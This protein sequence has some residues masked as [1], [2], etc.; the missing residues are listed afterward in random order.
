MFIIKRYEELDSIRGLAS[1]TVVICHIISVSSA[2]GLVVFLSTTPFLHLFF[3]SHEAVIMFFVLSGFVLSLPALSGKKQTYSEFIIRRIARIYIPYVITILI[4]VLLKEKFSNGGIDGLTEWFNRLWV[5][6]FNWELFFEHLFLIG[7]FNTDAYNPVIWTLSHEMRI[8][9]IFPLILVFILKFNWKYSL[10]LGLFFSCF[11]SLLHLKFG[12]NKVDFTYFLSIHYVFMF[13]IGAVLAK[14][15]D[16]L[17]N[18]FRNIPKAIRIVFLI[19]GL[20]LYTYSSWFFPNIEILHNRTL[21][22]WATSLGCAILIIVALGSSLISSVL[23]ANFFR[24]LGKISY[25]LYLIHFMVL[26][27]LINVFYDKTPMWSL[28]FL[29]VIISI[30]LATASYYFI[31]IPSVNLGKRLTFKT[32]GRNKKAA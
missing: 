1:L 5:D 6:P 31:E 16:F 32:I 29:T 11:G 7:G 26:F 28:W 12:L 27:T 4:A 9:I 20:L 18:N 13:I 8:S 17:I 23:K 3:A 10:G 14:H 15:K 24:F 2:Y 25:S 21:E 19:S 22:E 30:T